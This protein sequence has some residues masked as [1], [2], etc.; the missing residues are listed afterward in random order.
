MLFKVLIYGLIVT[1]MVVQ[2]ARVGPGEVKYLGFYGKMG[3]KERERYSLSRVKMMFSLFNIQFYAWLMLVY[4]APSL[5]ALLPWG[6]AQLGAVL[7]LHF[8]RWA[9][10]WFCRR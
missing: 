1:G 2:V 4:A 6:L 5:K 3:Q 7:V 10:E 8:T 9:L